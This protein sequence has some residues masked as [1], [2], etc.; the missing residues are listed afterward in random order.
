MAKA[1]E[2][3]R[4]YTEISSKIYN[5]ASEPGQEQSCGSSMGHSTIF[6]CTWLQA[7]EANVVSLY[8]PFAQNNLNDSFHWERQSSQ[9]LVTEKEIYLPLEISANTRCLNGRYHKQGPAYLGRQSVG[10]SSQ[11]CSGWQRYRFM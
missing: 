7:T 10:S 9:F 5:R 6:C 1:E 4:V 3:V 11:M 8:L 2:L